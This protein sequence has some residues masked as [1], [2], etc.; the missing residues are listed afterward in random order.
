MPDKTDY[1]LGTHDEELA[2]LGLQHRLWRATALECWRRAG[3]NLGSRVVDIGAGPGYATVDLAELVGPAGGVLAIERSPRFLEFA[4]KACAVR[5]LTNVQF[6]EADLMLEPLGELN[7]DF[8]WCRWVASFVASPE[9]LVNTIA[10]ALRPGGVAI[11]HEYMDYRTFRV[12]PRRRAIESFVEQVIASWKA[13]GGEPDV[14]V[15]FPTLF[16]AAGLRVVEANPRIL[17]IT[18]RDYAWQWP[19][20]FVEINLARLLELGRVDSDWAE[21]VRRDFREAESDPATLLNTPLF[22]EVI[23][24]REEKTE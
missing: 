4:K 12:A 10:A 9:K 16:R 15:M 18:P 19:A 7:Y 21:S 6:R 13:S 11:F 22:L 20:S 5:G 1:V 14:A 23:A 3:I 2:R 24:R 8:T 17:T